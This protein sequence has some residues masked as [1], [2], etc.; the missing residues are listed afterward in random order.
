MAARATTLG[1][2]LHGC[3]YKSEV[4]EETEGGNQQLMPVASTANIQ[5]LVE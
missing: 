2:D 1:R 4:A 5:T 3:F